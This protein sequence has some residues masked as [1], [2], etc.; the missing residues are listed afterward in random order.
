MNVY[1]PS[2]LGEQI[3]NCKLKYKK[4]QE[5]SSHLDRVYLERTF[6]EI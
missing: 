2:Y 4:S 6:S 1:I 5:I 3:S